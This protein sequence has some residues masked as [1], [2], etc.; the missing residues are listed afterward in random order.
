MRRHE[1]FLRHERHEH[2]LG[3]RPLTSL[4][5]L[6]LESLEDLESLSRLVKAGG[7]PG[8]HPG[9]WDSGFVGH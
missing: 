1:H 9:Q 6:P 8:V 7:I 5:E 4:Y 3:H 2:C